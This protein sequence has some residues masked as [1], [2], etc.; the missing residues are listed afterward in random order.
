MFVPASSVSGF[1]FQGLQIRD[2]TAG[3]ERGASVAEIIAPP[4]AR[5]RRAR[6]LRSHKFYWIMEGTLSFEIDG[7]AETLSAGDMAIV[8]Q[9]STFSYQTHSAQAR[10]L[11]VHTPPFA[12]EAEI[13][14]DD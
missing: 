1:D 8:P 2:Y 4:Q 13:F 10:M 12:A 5:H 3:M 6:S 7:V 11:L 14:T 9:G